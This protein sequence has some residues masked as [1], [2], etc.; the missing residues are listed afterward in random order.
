MTLQ[1]DQ[2]AVRLSSMDGQHNGDDRHSVDS[3]DSWDD[4]AEEKA[5]DLHDLH[6]DDHR[7]VSVL[8]VMLE[9]CT[10]CIVNEPQTLIAAQSIIEDGIYSYPR[11]VEL[12]DQLGEV[13]R[14]SETN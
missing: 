1:N 3:D 8:H 11:V 12:T 14:N 4:R 9:F 2:E 5:W 7:G 6:G 13:K 10:K